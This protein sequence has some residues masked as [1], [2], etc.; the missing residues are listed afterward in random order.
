VSRWILHVDMDAFFPSVEQVLDPG[1]TGRAVIVGGPPESRG[2]VSSASYE[3][4]RY[5]VHAA[6][7]TSQAKRLCPDGVF[8]PGNHE[9]YAEYS[10]W[11]LTILERF[12][13]LVD[14]A[15]IDEAYLDVTGCE[16]LLE[17]QD[18]QASPTLPQ[19]SGV[20][21]DPS[22]AVRVGRAIKA[23]VRRET[24]LTCSVGVAPNRLLAKT[25]SG[26]QKPDGLTVLL[27]EDVP[28]LIW[29]KPVGFLHGVGPSSVDHLRRLGIQSVG[30]LAHYPLEL[31]ARE[32]GVSGRHLHDA[33][34]GRDDTPVLPADSAG[35][36]K[37]LSRET[38]FAKDV[39]DLAELQ[40]T[41][42]GLADAVARRLRRHGY[43]GRTVVI[44]IRKADFTTVT[45]SRTLPEATDLAEDIHAEACQALT[46][47]WKPGLEV[48]LLGVGVANLQRSQNPPTTLFD[49]SEKLRRVSRVVDRIKDRFGER[50]LTRARLLEPSG[51]GEEPGGEG[52]QE[53]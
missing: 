24:G 49:P 26:L 23:V 7:P 51:R 21:P 39:G 32:F 27:V 45:R 46:A 28:R 33:A 53:S 18:G 22:A 5:G 52:D 47:F 25:A 37:S 42:L 34:N 10:R 20:G 1:L 38:T 41:L 12:T 35:E 14:Q 50:S 36:A 30:D 29:P 19:A 15:S 6:M 9:A 4:R 13:P 43:V 16:H 11:V 44:K 17:P 2:V 40:G 3:A 31:L 48:R 8:L